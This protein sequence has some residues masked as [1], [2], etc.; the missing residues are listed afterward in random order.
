MESSPNTLQFV[1][2][3]M[4]GL[5]GFRHGHSYALIRGFPPMDDDDEAQEVVTVLD[6]LFTGVVR[7]SCAKDFS[8]LCLRFASAA[9][10]A[11]LEGRIGKIRRLKK[12]YLLEQG[13][14]ESYVVASELLVAE[15]ALGGGDESPLAAED[16]SFIASHPP[17]SPVLRF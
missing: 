15:F 3:R 6:L 11:D 14:L 16:Q 8:P 17:L 9:E 7:I 4:F 10:V 1:E 5:Y 12:V 2:S 13:S